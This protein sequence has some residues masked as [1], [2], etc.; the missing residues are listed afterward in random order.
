MSLFK[1]VTTFALSED[2]PDVDLVALEA[3]A[4]EHASHQPEPS[5]GYTIGFAPALFGRSPTR[6][7]V[8]DG[9][10]L[11]PEPPASRGSAIEARLYAEDPAKNWQPQ[12]GTPEAELYE[13]FLKPQ[14]WV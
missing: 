11:D 4:G 7:H 12:A 5:Q 1:N 9:G 13:V 3:A 10:R 6:V 8:A 2:Q 14:D